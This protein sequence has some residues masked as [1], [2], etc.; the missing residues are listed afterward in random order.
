MRTTHHR[1]AFLDRLITGSVA[2]GHTT[3]RAA[4]SAVGASGGSSRPRSASPSRLA[5]VGGRAWIVQVGSYRRR[6]S[7]SE[8]EPIGDCHSRGSERVARLPAITTAPG[9]GQAKRRRVGLL[10][11]RVQTTAGPNAA[12]DCQLAEHVGVP[13]RDRDARRL[14]DGEVRP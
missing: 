2:R 8:A 14:D 3:S 12:D 4:A 6:D 10:V 9:A 5:A 11:A 13:T 7:L 1:P